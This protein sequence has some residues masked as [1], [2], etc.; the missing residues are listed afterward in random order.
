MM[1]IVGIKWEITFCVRKVDLSLLLSD[2]DCDKLNVNFKTEA[3]RRYFA[4]VLNRLRSSVCVIKT[5]VCNYNL[6]T[7]IEFWI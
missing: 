3:G 6:E 7:Y 4:D 1:G 5:L 2:Q